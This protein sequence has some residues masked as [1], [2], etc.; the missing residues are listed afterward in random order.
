MDTLA[1]FRKFFRDLRDE[2]VMIDGAIPDYLPNFGHRPIGGAIWGDVATFVPWNVYRYYGKLDELAESYP[3]MKDWVDWID[4]GDA[5][6][7]EAGAPDGGRKYIW[8]YNFTFGDWVALDGATPMSYKGG[9]DDAYLASLY[10]FRSAQIVADSAALL[11]KA[12]DEK[13]Y[14][15]L[16]EK[17]REAVLREYFTP[18]GRLAIDSQTALFIALKFGV[19][20]D[21]ERLLTQLNTRFQKDLFKIKGGFAG[22]PQMCTV[23]A[24]LGMTELAYDFLFNEEFPGW[25]YEVNLGATTIWERWNSVSPDGTIADNEMNSLNHYAYG[26]VMEFL[27]GYGLGIREAAPGYRKAVIAPNPDIRLR[28]SG[29]YDS[30]AGRYECSWRIEENGEL[31]ISVNVPF[32][33]SATLILP[34][35]PEGRTLELKPG[36]YTYSYVPTTDYRKPYGWDSRLKR[37]VKDERAMEILSKH[38]PVVAGMAASGDPERVAT[39]LRELSMAGFL[40][41]NQKALAEAVAELEELVVI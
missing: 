33:C 5:A 13:H 7:G 24:E 28:L 30:V 9:T 8:D 29:S 32:G 25:L 34:R 16:S 17:I 12:E 21:K 2:Q 41:I 36:S 19:F 27:Y 22:A 38:E 35:D 1:F 18:T 10:Y 4:R 39:S 37:L 3:M 40:P 20:L 14:R 11:G 6:R 26:S 15:K 31:T 23:L